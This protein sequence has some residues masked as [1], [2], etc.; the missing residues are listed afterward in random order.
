VLRLVAVR[1]RGLCGRLRRWLVLG[2]VGVVVGGFLG[3]LRFGGRRLVF[4]GML[5]FGGCCWWLM[6]WRLLVRLF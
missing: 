2:G 1:S 4:V 6:L 3:F 5:C